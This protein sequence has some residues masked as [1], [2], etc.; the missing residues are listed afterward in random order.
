MTNS[1]PLIYNIPANQW[2]H[3]FVVSQT[4]P[5]STPT[6]ST[7]TQTSPAASSDNS[8]PPA[9]PGRPFSIV[10]II[11]CAVGGVVIIAMV[12]FLFYRRHRK[13]KLE[14]YD[15]PPL[16]PLVEEDMEHFRVFRKKGLVGW[17]DDDTSM[18]DDSDNKSSKDKSVALSKKAAKRGQCSSP[19]LES[20]SASTLVLQQTPPPPR[21]SR[22]KRSKGLS[23]REY[24]AVVTVTHRLLAEDSPETPKP[25]RKPMSQHSSPST[26]SSPSTLNNSIASV[27]SSSGLPSPT[28]VTV[29]KVSDII[30]Q[31]KP[32]H[33]VHSKGRGR[34]TPLETPSSS[35]IV[36]SS[37]HSPQYVPVGYDGLDIWRDCGQEEVRSPQLRGPRHETSPAAWMAMMNTTRTANDTPQSLSYRANSPQTTQVIELCRLNSNSGGEVS[38]YRAYHPTKPR[39]HQVRSEKPDQEPKIK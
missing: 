21:T 31:P 11:G 8:A 19:L 26:G 2:V 14:D 39:R 3:N 27:V 6:M 16:P 33:Q 23:E 25:R 12:G 5:L 37:R 30:S 10:I 9:S 4:L 24:P 28:K 18:Y 7:V 1:T 35:S 32:S 36:S 20:S 13:A 15:F 38:G 34:K 22:K 17:D 29:K